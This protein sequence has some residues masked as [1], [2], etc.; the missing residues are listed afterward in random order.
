MFYYP[1]C[2]KLPIGKIDNNI[3]YLD[4]E[5]DANFPAYLIRL[6]CATNNSCQYASRL[7]SILELER[8]KC[9]PTFI[10]SQY[11]SDCF[12]SL[13]GVKKYLTFD[14]EAFLNGG[15]TQ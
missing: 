4:F 5:L 15:V 7:V 1:K 9:S 14:F 8:F 12:T 13:K 11:L 2:E 3:V 10:L 6:Y